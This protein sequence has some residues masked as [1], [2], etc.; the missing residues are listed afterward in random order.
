MGLSLSVLIGLCFLL[1]GAAFVLGF[2]RLHNPNSPPTPLDQN[3]GFGL[4]VA[5]LGALFFQ[6]AWFALVLLCTSLLSLPE[7]SVGQFVAL[8]AGESQSQHALDAAASMQRFPIRV[9][10]YFL[11]I[12]AL[13][14]IV[15]RVVNKRTKRRASASWYDLL[16]PTMADFVW[17]TVDVHM[18]GCCFLFAGVVREFCVGKNGDLERVV[19]AF[20]VK[21]PLDIDAKPQG[22]TKELAD[23]WIEIPG[24]FVVLQVGDSKTLNVDY[25]FS[26]SDDEDGDLGGEDETASSIPKNSPSRSP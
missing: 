18:D 9:V 23:H 2:S 7:P 1:P 10:S 4:V 13:G 24:E 25:F 12:T 3:F 8:L 11:A 15:G 17:L 16:R 14:A 20:A 19:L 6:G 21:R 26:D 22:S 5:L